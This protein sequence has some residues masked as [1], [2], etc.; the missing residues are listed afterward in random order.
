MIHQISRISSL[1]SQPHSSVMQP[2]N[3][4][5]SH[6]GNHYKNN[7]DHLKE[8]N[9]GF[10]HSQETPSNVYHSGATSSMNTSTGSTSICNSG[11]SCNVYNSG[12]SSS[13]YNSSTSSR[14]C[15]PSTS[16]NMVFPNSSSS[17]DLAN[18]SSN[19]QNHNSSGMHN[20]NLYPN[21]CNTDP[22]PNVYNSLNVHHS[23]SS[24]NFLPYHHIAEKDVHRTM[25]P[26]TLIDISEDNHRDTKTY[27]QLE[28]PKNSHREKIVVVDVEDDEIIE[29]KHIQLRSTDKIKSSDKYQ[30]IE[31]R[32]P[33]KTENQRN[34]EPEKKFSLNTTDNTKQNADHSNDKVTP[35]E[36]E[37]IET[38][39][40]EKTEMTKTIKK[41][42][43]T[44][45][46]V[47]KE[48]A[49]KETMKT[50]SIPSTSKGISHIQERND[51]TEAASPEV[52]ISETKKK[53]ESAVVRRAKMNGKQRTYRD[54]YN[55][56][57]AQ[58]SKTK[59]NEDASTASEKQ[60]KTRNVSVS[61][62]RL[63]LP[64]L[65]RPRLHGW[66][67]EGTPRDK[68]VYVSNDTP[69]CVRRCYPSMKHVQGDVICVRDC[70][71][72]RSSIK[73]T[74]MPFVAKVTEL[75]ENPTNGEMTMS[76]LWYYRPEQIEMNRR[77]HCQPNEIFASKH[78]DVN[79]VA[80]I[81]DKCYVLTYSEFCRFKKRCSMS[82]DDTKHAFSIV[83]QGRNY[84]RKNRLPP[85]NIASELVMFC[86]RVYD[87]RRKR[88][89][90]NPL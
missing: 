83:P 67:W 12:T 19:L 84:S 71:Y 33:E 38:V 72:L 7:T 65:E 45:K 57:L 90:K 54:F 43:E 17:M 73:R 66:S 82:T 80:C 63:V 46:T 30:K 36:E 75:W 40:K 59:K 29:K 86:H 4:S 68:K 60:L 85:P 70:V 81:E 42:K 32:K 52:T 39:K 56:P 89:L 51:K 9:Y 8:S 55:R 18:S 87:Y 28:V 5:A 41:E 21:M 14:M 20:S 23:N 37:K 24:S 62:P 35:K 48:K 26:P 15:Q 49:P 34:L 2:K 47:K 10:K 13:A 69:P 50:E 27:I 16:S 88:M 77:V 78:R 58:L 1:E 64:R 11:T 74:N 61:I 3:N 53:K 25:R 79:S 22:S 44:T 6:A 31:S 76:L